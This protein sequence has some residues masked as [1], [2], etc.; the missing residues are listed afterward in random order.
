MS[1]QNFPTSL[2]PLI[3]Q[4][5]LERDFQDALR[6]TII[7]RSIAD[8]ET[9]PNN[10]GE[11]LTKTR[12]GLK[13]PVTTPLSPSSNTNL[14]NGL[15]PKSFTVEQY[16]LSIDMYGDTIDLNQVTQAVG[17]KRQ[18]LQ[19][20]TVNGTQAGQSIDRIAQ[21]V[22]FNAHLGGNTRVITALGGNNPT[23]AVDDVRGFLA[24]P[25]S[26]G[27]DNYVML[28]V[29]TSNKM[30]VYVNGNPY[31]LQSYT[32]DA[33]NVSTAPNGISGTLTMDASV[34]QADG[35]LAASV[36]GYYAPT[37][38]RPNA[39]STTKALT[40]GD[41]LTMG[42]LLDATT[43]L[44][45]NGVPTVG[46]LYNAYIDNTSG[47]ELFSDP[48]FKLLYQ[49][50]NAAEE[51]K[52]GRVIELMNI[53]L[54]PTT[55][56]PQQTLGSYKVHR[57]IVCGTGALIEGEFASTGY[58]SVAG[59]AILN[60]VDGVAMVTRPSLDRLSQVIAQSWYYIGGFTVPT[61]MTAK[62]SII[63]T[64]SNAMYKRGVVIE[65]I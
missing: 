18:F 61:D 39:R 41:T 20:A 64:A 1:I 45:N 2:Q 21:K 65:H 38:L 46:G 5:F 25:T 63:P 22:L 27:A 14:D 3:Q 40:S 31:N 23:I 24:T 32:I 50:S 47:R 7:Y 10:V 37:I 59:Q 17:I 53:R 34:L 54:L 48:D 30:V 28:P 49:G 55:E 43:Q 62:Q 52:L 16:T 58:Q 19:N 51:F 35:A 60:V 42:L 56:A 4:N 57:P 8:K 15:T 29:S 13:A 33:T 9:F 11:T 6:S 12:P 26:P 36:V 44:R